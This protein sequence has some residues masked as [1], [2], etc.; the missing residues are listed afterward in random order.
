MRVAVV[1]APEAVELREEPT[2]AFVPDEARSRWAPA[3]LAAGDGA[4]S[5]NVRRAGC[6]RTGPSR[7]APP[8]WAG[9][10]WPSRDSAARASSGPSAGVAQDGGHTGPRMTIENESAIIIIP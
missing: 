7:S 9:C 1:A 5:A 8:T 10:T 2:P 3:P 4:R 6:R